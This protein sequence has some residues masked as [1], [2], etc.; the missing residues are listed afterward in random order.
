MEYPR[1]SASRGA[2]SVAKAPELHP[3]VS[4]LSLTI[5]EL[6]WADLAS[7]TTRSPHS[8]PAEGPVS[9]SGVRVALACTTRLLEE[10]LTEL[11]D[12]AGGIHL[13][14]PGAGGQPDVALL[15]G[16]RRAAPDDRGDSARQRW[17]CPAALLDTG[18]RV[19][20]VGAALQ[21]FQGYLPPETEPERLLLC[22]RR[23]A[24]GYPDAPP[25]HLVPLVRTL[26]APPLDE[27]DREILRHLALGRSQA[28]ILR[29]MP[30]SE[31]TLQRR[32][33]RLLD[34]WDGTDGHH[35]GA[36]AVALGLGWP[37]ES[38]PIG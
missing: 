18:G 16:D 7:S 3:P 32:V 9:P 17:D 31:R 5:P 2:R 19:G 24:R 33:T 1:A 13:W 4:P 22:L 8:G 15:D 25:P 37:W 36:I 30:M 35:L 29:D 11:I 26:A 6:S 12:G 23:L 10:R 34:A 21:G 28:Q 27:W 20:P 14:T 38:Q